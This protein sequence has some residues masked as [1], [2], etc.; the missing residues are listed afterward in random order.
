MTPPAPIRELQAP[1]RFFADR[2][3]LT[4]TRLERLLGSAGGGQV[5]YADVFI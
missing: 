2:Y 4:A 5:E 1:E 3:G